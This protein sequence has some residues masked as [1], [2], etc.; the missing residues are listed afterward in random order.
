MFIWTTAP[1]LAHILSLILQNN[2]TKLNKLF[3]IE[4]QEWL[5]LKDVAC[6]PLS[7]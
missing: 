2:I 3:D 6:I 1:D 4:S 5:F 7:T